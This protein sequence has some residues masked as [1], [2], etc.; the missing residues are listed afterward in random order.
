MPVTVTYNNTTHSTTS[1]TGLFYMCAAS[2]ASK[3]LQMKTITGVAYLQNA[4]MG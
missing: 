2:W 3:P 1:M 4:N